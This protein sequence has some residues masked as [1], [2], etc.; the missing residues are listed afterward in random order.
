MG[1]LKKYDVVFDTTT[2]L[3]YGG[4]VQARGNNGLTKLST[5][6]ILPILFTSLILLG[7]LIYTDTN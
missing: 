4:I 5:V 2:L 6:P 1:P 7:T 3:C